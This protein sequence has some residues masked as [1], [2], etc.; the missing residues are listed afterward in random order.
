MD[1]LNE[2]VSLQKAAQVRLYNLGQIKSLSTFINDPTRLDIMRERYELQSS[3]GRRDEIERLDDEERMEQEK[4]KLATKLPDA[5]KMF[6]NNKT[7]KL[8]FT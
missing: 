2:G 3:L 1:D 8:A 6:A 5:V 4:D 7:G